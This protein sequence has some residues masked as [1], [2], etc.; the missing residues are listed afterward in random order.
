M[1]EGTYSGSVV[2]SGSDLPA[3]NKTVAVNLRVTS[4]PIIQLSSN[5]LKVSSSAGAA[6]RQFR[7][8]YSNR[9]LGTLSLGAVTATG[10]VA[11]T[12]GSAPA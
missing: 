3:D 6:K 9:G 7:F 5:L 10:A 4:Q 11:L 8:T 12:T 1:A 2:L